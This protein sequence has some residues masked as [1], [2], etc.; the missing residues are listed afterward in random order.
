MV[1]SGGF[2]FD[3]F[4][5]F[6]FPSLSCG[7]TLLNVNLMNDDT[8]L[9]ASLRR[10]KDLS[11]LNTCVKFQLEVVMVALVVAAITAAAIH[12]YLGVNVLE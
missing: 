11:N 3:F 6:I 8:I 10:A 12:W 1:A 9:C 4:F 7:S 2:C 5:L